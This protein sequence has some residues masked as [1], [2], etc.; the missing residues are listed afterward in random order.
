VKSEAA[1]VAFMLFGLLRALGF[2][3]RDLAGFIMTKLAYNE[4]RPWKADAN[5][6]FSGGK[7]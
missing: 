4:T 5:G 6:K 3:H 7:P 2:G 1:D